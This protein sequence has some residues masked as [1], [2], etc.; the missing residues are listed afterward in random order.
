MRRLL[1]EGG[2]EQYRRKETACEKSHSWREHDQG[3]KWCDYRMYTVESGVGKLSESQELLC[4]SFVGRGE[5]LVTDT[6]VT[7]LAHTPPCPC[8]FSPFG[9]EE[10]CDLQFV[11]LFPPG[12]A[13]VLYTCL[14][15]PEAEMGARVAELEKLPSASPFLP[16]PTHRDRMKGMFV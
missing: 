16:P 5:E 2:E 14:V 15:Q 11:I 13:S 7:P 10:R 12:F 6:G 3:A 8:T 9:R 4:E 1:S